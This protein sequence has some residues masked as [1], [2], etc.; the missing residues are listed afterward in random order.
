MHTNTQPRDAYGCCCRRRSRFEHQAAASGDYV[1]VARGTDGSVKWTETIHNLITDEGLRRYLSTVLGGAS[2]DAKVNTWYLG[3]IGA[4]PNI[5]G[6]NTMASHSGWSEVTAY[7]ETARRTWTP[8]A[9]T[10]SITNAASP[11]VFTCSANGTV[12]AGAFLAS[13]PAKGGT[14]GYLFAA[15][16]FSGGAKTLDSGETLTV[17]ATYSQAR[18]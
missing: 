17:T 1:V 14:A 9:A 11:A 7:S 15:G 6:A 3:L 8:A 4:N 16:Q 2:G 12:I 5:S 18:A 13:D 10:A